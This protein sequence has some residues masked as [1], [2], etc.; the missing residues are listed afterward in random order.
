MGG[1]KGPPAPAEFRAPAYAIVAGA[2][3]PAMKLLRSSALRP[4]VQPL[5][6]LC[7]YGAGFVRR[8]TPVYPLGSFKVSRIAM[9]PRE[10]EGTKRILRSDHGLKRNRPSTESCVLE[11]RGKP[12]YINRL[13]A[14]L[15]LS[16]GFEVS[17]DSVHI[18]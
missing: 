3:H 9:P 2:L 18:G 14:Y 1:P 12:F 11:S 10:N 8:K 16:E 5:A 6:Q 7:H 13:G 15:L 17:V 4:I